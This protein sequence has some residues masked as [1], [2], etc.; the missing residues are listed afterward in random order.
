MLGKLKSAIEGAEISQEQKEELLDYLKPAMREA[1]KEKP[2]KESAKQNLQKVSET[3]KNLKE[4]T[5]AGKSLWQ[6]GTEVFKAIA[7][8][9]GVA[10]AFFG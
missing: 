10:T 8:W 1:G 5:E 7:P 4:T 3:M 9:I 6:T 2:D